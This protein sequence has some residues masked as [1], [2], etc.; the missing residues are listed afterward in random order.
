MNLYI[1]SD[2]GGFEMK[3][4]IVEYLNNSSDIP[5]F[6]VEDL[7]PYELNPNDDY[8]IFG[9]K[10]A[11]KVA[12]DKGSLGILICR[13]GNGMVIAANKVKGAYAALCFIDKH[14]QMARNDDNANILC[15]DADYESEEVLLQITRSFLNATFAGSGTRHERRFNEIRAYE[16][17]HCN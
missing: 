10:L 17:L 16:E 7:G 3:K 8:P 2:H 13:S 12:S 15:L 1:S 11:E 9:I 5:R 14:A 4:D 6:E